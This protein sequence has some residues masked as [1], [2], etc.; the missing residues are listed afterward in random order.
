MASGRLQS[1]DFLRGVAIL[2]V[3]VFHVFLNFDPQV[4]VISALAGL[5]V[6]GV[7]LFFLVSALTMSLMWDRRSGEDRPIIKFYIRR[8]FRI[9]PPFWLAIIGYLILSGAAPS[10][11]WPSGIDLRHIA[12]TSTFLHGF[13][14]D[15]INTVV[16]GGWSI[17]VEMTFYAVFP[18]IV[19]VNKS[20]T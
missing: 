6:Y 14:P 18:F 13:W 3:V 16:P 1:F 19:A 8:F 12:M 15:T 20:S 4:K 5:G 17:A 10:S 11:G 7:Q 2:G 9:A